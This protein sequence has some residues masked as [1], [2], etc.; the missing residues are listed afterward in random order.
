MT[1]EKLTPDDAIAPDVRIFF[2][3]L[4]SA[5]PT[6]A[7]FCLLSSISDI[8]ALFCLLSSISDYTALFLVYSVFNACRSDSKTTLQLHN[9]RVE[10]RGRLRIR[11]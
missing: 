1:A 8:G 10:L 9:I 7:L 4:T 3:L 2:V 6:S 5:Y 11:K